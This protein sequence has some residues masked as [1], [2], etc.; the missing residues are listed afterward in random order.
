[1]SFETQVTIT[2]DFDSADK[3]KLMF[4]FEELT[5]LMAD[6]QQGFRTTTEVT[7]KRSD[8]ARRGGGFD[9]EDVLDPVRDYDY[10]RNNEL[11]QRIADELDIDMYDDFTDENLSEMY[12]FAY[13]QNEEYENP[14]FD[15]PTIE[16]PEYVIDHDNNPDTAGIV[17]TMDVSYTNKYSVAEKS[18]RHAFSGH[19]YKIGDSMSLDFD[20][21]KASYSPLASYSGNPEDSNFNGT[22]NSL[23]T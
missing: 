4:D 7:R 2:P 3:V 8:T 13:D 18:K 5:L 23:Y 19:R 10:Y 22:T 11:W 16:Y 17:P 20:A 15:E 6:F 9:Y 1:M 21:L 14:T 12:S